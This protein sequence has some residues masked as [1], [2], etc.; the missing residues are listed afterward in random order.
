MGGDDE[1]DGLDSVLG[2]FLKGV[3][4]LPAGELFG[5]VGYADGNS[6]SDSGPDDNGGLA[7]GAGGQFN[8]GDRSGIRADYTRYEIS[9]DV[10]A[11]S[12]SYVFRLN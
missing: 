1:G 3:L 11:F 4:P 2:V 7:V 12:I 10:D 6:S 8:F 9:G 5:R